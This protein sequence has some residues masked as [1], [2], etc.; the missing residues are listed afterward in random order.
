M[1]KV[2]LLFLVCLFSLFVWDWAHQNTR[3]TLD[4]NFNWISRKS[5]VNKPLPGSYSL[6]QSPITVKNNRLNL[7]S[8]RGNNEFVSKKPLLNDQCLSLD[9]SVE[10]NGVFT[11]SL[12]QAKEH[13]SVL[14]LS[15]SKFDSSSLVTMNSNGK[16]LK[17]TN[18]N[19]D[20]NELSHAKFNAC[21]FENS[22]Q[23]KIN[24]KQVFDIN[25][26]NLEMPI[27]W[28]IGSRSLPVF[29][30]NV[31][32]IDTK[33]QVVFYDNFDAHHPWLIFLIII[34]IM[35]CFYFIV[36]PIRFGD[37][38]LLFCVLHL[39][40]V[41]LTFFDQHFWANVTKQELAFNNPFYRDV[42][43][44]YRSL[45]FKTLNHDQAHAY[46]TNL[47]EQFKKGGIFEDLFDY[48]YKTDE[49]RHVFK[50]TQEDASKRVLVI[51]SSQLW[52]MGATKQEL[53]FLNRLNFYLNSHQ[54]LSKVDLFALSKPGGTA[55][56][57]YKQFIES[58][59]SSIKYDQMIVNLSFND[60]VNHESFRI[61]LKDFLKWSS[62]KV[63]T[64]YFSLES[65]SP[66][67]NL[68]K[69]IENHKIMTELAMEHQV[70]IIDSNA[71]VKSKSVYHSGHIWWDEVHLTN[72]GQDLLAKM[73]AE[74]LVNKKD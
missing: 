17:R 73:L 48:V 35:F 39:P 6:T 41:G 24:Q 27:F 1:K 21:R 2:Y 23:I 38:V 16:Y 15:R 60:A 57:L 26:L 71:Y 5:L 10:N 59:L 44:T 31:S 20:P 52:G 3:S 70:N 7:S 34:M 4:T 14:I 19:Y 29:V 68:P 55:K 56:S 8:W 11:F 28:S 13:S 42:F 12:R 69:V 43:Y 54:S 33:G 36:P 47:E 9:L 67:L 61:G 66:E 64:V 63:K 72:W 65:I 58:D 30:D 49:F 32:V 37:F 50:F 40:V 53:S 45:R 22:I 51:S 74:R 18:I 46:A 62:S 25:I